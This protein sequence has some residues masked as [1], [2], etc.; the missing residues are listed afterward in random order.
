M[1]LVVHMPENFMLRNLDMSQV[2]LVE[3]DFKTENPISA[4]IKID[5]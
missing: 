4:N 5:C 3:T 1:H 2:V